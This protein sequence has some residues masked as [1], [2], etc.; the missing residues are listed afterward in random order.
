MV[1]VLVAVLLAVGGPS[2]QDSLQRNRLQTTVSN[3]ASALSFAR[4]EAVIRSEPV[5]ICAT[6]DTA[7][8]G[9]SNWETGYLIFVDNGIGAGGAPSDGTLNGN[10]EL[11]RIGDP[12]P[13]G[14]TVRTINFPANTAVVFQENGRVLQNVSGTFTF[15]DA[16][17]AASARGIIVAVSGQGRLAVD[18]DANG[19]SE[20]NLGSSLA[21]P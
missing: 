1:L 17:G 14:V 15:C 12:A 3:M 6:T 19:T 5:A 21:C 2:F 11:L 9:G 7:S 18:F 13:A 8:C 20:D 16:R 4:S 10:E